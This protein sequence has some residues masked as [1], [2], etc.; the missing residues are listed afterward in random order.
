[1][2]TIGVMQ[3][4]RALGHA[5]RA[6]GVLQHRDVARSDVGAREGHGA[7]GRYGV[8]E[9]GVAGQR[10]GRHHLAQG[11]HH[12]VH[13]QALGEAQKIAHRGHDDVLH[14]G[15]RDRLLESRGEVLQHDHRL[16]AGILELMGKLARGV[17][18]IDVDGDQAG[19][20]HGGQRH[21]ILQHVGH[22][23]R[24]ARALREAPALQPG[25]QR[26]GQGVDVA[27]GDGLVH[28]DIGALVAVLGEALLEQRHHA[29]IDRRIDIRRH[30]WR[31]A[32]EPEPVHGS[33]RVR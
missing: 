32:L 9:L 22:H 15:A 8:I 19:A 11:A 17:E 24:D 33:S 2:A 23:D 21:R 10:E 1:M 27:E 20:Q 31:I 12:E 26:L 4:C 3:Q 18:R 29:G 5:R 14:R 6:A 16:G 28:A 30:A 13:D 7:A 25:G